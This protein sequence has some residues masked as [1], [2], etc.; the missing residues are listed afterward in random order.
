VWPGFRTHAVTV[1]T[2]DNRTT[3]RLLSYT[4]DRQPFVT[5]PPSSRRNVG[6]SK[7]ANGSGW[8]KID[9]GYGNNNSNSSTLEETILDPPAGSLGF[10][11]MDS[12]FQFPSIYTISSIIPTTRR[13]R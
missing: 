6:H 4:V 10:Y 13:R 7:R 9:R 11:R 12:S 2:S 1:A 8:K 3:K 5:L